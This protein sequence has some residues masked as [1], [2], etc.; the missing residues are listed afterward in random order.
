MNPKQSF[1][2]SNIEELINQDEQ[3]SRLS[4]LLAEQISIPVKIT[5]SLSDD[6]YGQNTIE[7]TCES[8]DLNEPYE[9]GKWFDGFIVTNKVSFAFDGN[10]AQAINII[11]DMRDYCVTMTRLDKLKMLQKEMDK[12][13]ERAGAVYRAKNDDGLFVSVRAK[14]AELQAQIRKT[15]ISIRL[16]EDKIKPFKI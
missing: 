11:H 5:Y 16:L 10:L 7:K 8:F 4:E 15:E 12:D 1:E 2:T 3:D 9:Y 14:I 13:L 6:K